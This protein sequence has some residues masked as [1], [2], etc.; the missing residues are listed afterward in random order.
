MNDLRVTFKDSAIANA[1]E[2]PN[3]SEK[4]KKRSLFK[5]NLSGGW[6]RGITTAAAEDSNQAI[7]CP[8]MYIEANHYK[9]EDIYP[10]AALI[11]SL[12]SV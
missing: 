6:K 9:Y 7:G 12:L 1:K 5:R 3:L 10:N 8:G 4:K 11:M 2:E